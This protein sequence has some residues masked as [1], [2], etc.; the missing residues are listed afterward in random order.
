MTMDIVSYRGPGMAGGVSATL[1]RI[2]EDYCSS[3]ASWWH[4]SNSVLQR[5]CHGG[6]SGTA[7]LP[8]ELVRG[9]YRYCNEFLWPILHDMPEYATFRAGDRTAYQHL[10][11]VL[12]EHLE[13]SVAD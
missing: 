4:F 3:G 11:V 2:W 6:T 13:R 1:A 7:K 9:H 5:N 8:D 12:S 10:S